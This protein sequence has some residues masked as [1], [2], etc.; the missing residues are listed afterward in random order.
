[1]DMFH[2]RII[3]NHIK[4]PN[5]D[6]SCTYNEGGE[7]LLNSKRQTDLGCNFYTVQSTTR[8]APVSD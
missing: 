7:F 8:L 2:I 1:M 6:K 4:N 3:T 5:Y